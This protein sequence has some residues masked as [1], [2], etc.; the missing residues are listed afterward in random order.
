LKLG[1]NLKK[2]GNLTLWAVKLIWRS[3]K[4]GI[5]ACGACHIVGF[6]NTERLPNY[7]ENEGTGADIFCAFWTYV[8]MEMHNKFNFVTE[9][10]FTLLS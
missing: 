10:S 8:E 1:L 9:F 6:H 2:G 5:V 4:H 3:N 7:Y